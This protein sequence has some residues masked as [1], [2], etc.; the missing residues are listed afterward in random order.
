MFYG[1]GR[2]VRELLT[3]A[4][5]H[6]I[7]VGPRRVGKTS[8]LRRLCEQ[9]PARRP[10]LELVYLDLLGI[11]DPERI[12]RELVRELVPVDPAELAGEHDLSRLAE[13]LSEHFSARRGVV[14]ID[15]AD[16][17]VKADAARGFPLLSALRSLQSR[18]KCSVLLAG[19]W[20][21]FRATL[22]YD[23]P[24]YN[25]APIRRL[26]PLDP[27][28]GRALAEAHAVVNAAFSRK[29]PLAV[30]ESLLMQLVLYGFVVES[31]GGYDWTIPLLRATLLTAPERG[32]RRELLL[33][34]LPE[35][36]ARWAAPAVALP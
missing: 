6:T 13:L 28:D 36:P 31:E 25:F 26:G 7:L 3:A 34:E 30:L 14:V 10:E 12:V 35:D 29:V 33:R 11:D 1:R 19:Y 9:L 32:H 2:V 23:S 27:E 4:A 8:L 22:D 16:N 18:G 24:L 17:L 15:E 21:L 20:H 5:P